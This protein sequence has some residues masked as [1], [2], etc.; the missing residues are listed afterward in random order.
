M[1]RKAIK[2]KKGYEIP[3]QIN[4]GGDEKRVVLI[5]H[6]FGGSKDL[7]AAAAFSRLP[8]EYGIG[9]VCFDFPA[10]GESPAD[11]RKLRVENCV[12]DLE[13]V[14]EYARALV[15][16]AEIVYFATSFG[17]YITLV[18]LTAN[19]KM[20]CRA[21]LRSAALNM[22]EVLKRNFMPEGAR[23]DRDG[24]IELSVPVIGT[25]KVTPEFVGEL[26]K[27]DVFKLW[28]PG[29]ASLA[30]IH[31]S[32]DDVCDIS[33]ARRFAEL[34]GASLIEIEGAG[35]FGYPGG[36]ERAVMEAVAFFQSDTLED[37]TIRKID[38]SE[39]GE[40]LRVV[41]E[42]FMER[43]APKCSI[44]TAI[45]LR[46]LLEE[47][48]SS[49]NIALYG[50]FHEGRLFGAAV[51]K[52]DLSHMYLLLVRRKYVGYGVTRMLLDAV[53]KD[54]SADRITL[55]AVPFS[56]DMYR[57]LGFVSAAHTAPCGGLKLVPMQY[58]I[59]RESG[60]ATAGNNMNLSFCS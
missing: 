14:E 12:S 43:L 40:A 17:A 3:C 32:A 34:T 56:A 60:L 19:V 57:S 42:I 13:T 25:V 5:C 33:S 15:P 2:G 41:W 20:G 27:Y 23:P 36:I 50:A 51:M 55:N 9:T 31:G 54:S 16:E 45:C 46:R 58:I 39:A 38:E 18:Y 37:L 26:E 30:M 10:H 28:R 35:H 22:P 24:L 7:R 1:I 47:E 59:R 53:L 4:I 11:A 21:F 49:D 6:G 8:A 44:D 48:A 52:K 29:T